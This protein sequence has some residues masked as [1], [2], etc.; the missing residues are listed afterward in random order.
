MGDDFPLLASPAPHVG[1][2]SPV[3]RASPG[4]EANS[5]AWNRTLSWK[6]LLVNSPPAWAASPDKYMGRM[7]VEGSPGEGSWPSW[8]SAPPFPAPSLGPGPGPNPPRLPPN[9]RQEGEGKFSQDEEDEI[10]RFLSH[11]SISPTA[12]AED[13]GKLG[14]EPPPKTPSPRRRGFRDAQDDTLSTAWTP[15]SALNTSGQDSGFATEGPSGAFLEGPASTGSQRMQRPRG[16]GQGAADH[17]TLLQTSSPAGPSSPGVAADTQTN[18]TIE[19]GE[20]A[21]RTCSCCGRRFRESRLPVHEEICYRNAGT[22]KKRSVFESSRQRCSAV[23]GRWWSTPERK[24]NAGSQSRQGQNSRAC[25]PQVS[26]QPSKGVPVV[27][28]SRSTPTMQGTHSRRSP[29]GRS[30]RPSHRRADASGPKQSTTTSPANKVFVTSP[31]QKPER[32]RSCAGTRSRSRRESLRGAGRADLSRSHGHQAE[33]A[34]EHPAAARRTVSAERLRFTSSSPV[35]PDVSA[36]TEPAQ[37]GLGSE[38]RPQR[39]WGAVPAMPDLEGFQSSEQAT[40]TVFRARRSFAETDKQ[41]ALG[42]SGAAGDAPSG[43]LGSIIEDVAQLSAQVEKLLSRRKDVLKGTGHRYYARASS[44]VR[45]AALELSRSD[46]SVAEGDAVAHSR[47]ST[48]AGAYAGKLQG[49]S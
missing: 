19:L 32:S 14:H 39:A 10:S 42:N 38:G 3:P 1:Q 11:V 29:E 26:R 24:S 6:R 40:G 47:A 7:G 2:V 48:A 18:P 15:F 31:V 36:T 27:Q 34:P 20:V 28:R 45:D 23:S 13:I 16:S 5:G 33:A 22:G 41:E 17:S 35:A 49:F 44:D 8:R 43:L 30:P 46:S 21:L 12:Y 37:C 9:L 25:S 4:G